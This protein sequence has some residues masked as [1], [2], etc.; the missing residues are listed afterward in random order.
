[1]EAAPV[2]E[3]PRRRARAAA[4]E[5]GEEADRLS[6]LPDCLLHEILAR[7]GSRQAVRTSALSRRWRHVWRAVPRVDLDQRD[8]VLRGEAESYAASCDRLEDFA[9]TMLSPHGTAASPLDAFRLHLLD[10]GRNIVFG[11]WIRRAL[12][13]RPAS[14]DVRIDHGGA[15]DYPPFFSLGTGASV[16][17]G[18]ARL[19]RLHLFGVQIGF[20]TGDGKRIAQLLPVLEELHLESCKFAYGGPSTVAFPNLRSLAVVPRCT[21]A[22]YKM[23]VTSPRVESLRIFVPFSRAYGAPVH[24]APSEGNGV[25]ESLVSASISIYDIDQ[26]IFEPDRRLNKHKLD[27]LRSTRSMLDRMP[28]VRD[29]QLSGFTTIALLDKASQ[30]FPMLHKLRTL[31]LSD[32]DV[33]VGC[34]VLKSIFRNAPKL[35]SLRL[36]RCK[37]I[38]T[39]KR[40]RGGSSKSNKK[41][42]STSTCPDSPPSLFK[43]LQSVE[44]KWRREDRGGPDLMEFK[45]EISSEV[46][47]H[48]AKSVSEGTTGKN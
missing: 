23:T 34:H 22:T 14:V 40:K 2:D 3:P 44:I 33:G 31:L 21:T 35:E 4:D 48:C 19:T 11:R 37:F 13:L 18:T 32:C 36:H 43:N 27:F 28:N 24:L 39:P 12:L 1:M 9:D 8:F 26:E 45:K 17:I 16:G 29:L 41:S 42:S 30:E 5:E 15:S 46:Q 25:L 20:L 6:D 7:I 38:G 47:W 10:A